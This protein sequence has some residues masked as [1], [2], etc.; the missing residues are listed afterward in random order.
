[1]HVQRPGEQS[2]VSG[3]VQM[4]AQA[5]VRQA[6][7][8]DP[9]VAKRGPCVRRQPRRMKDVPDYFCTAA[10]YHDGAAIDLSAK[11]DTSYDVYVPRHVVGGEF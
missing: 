10:M 8:R 7:A 11:L 5:S 9:R 1:M 4:R 3:R 2:D 6:C